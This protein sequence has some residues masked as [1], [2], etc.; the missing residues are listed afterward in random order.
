MPCSRGGTP[1]DA[2]KLHYKHDGSG[3]KGHRSAS[4]RLSRSPSFSPAPRRVGACQR[5]SPGLVCAAVAG[6]LGKGDGRG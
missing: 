4:L 5:V 6:A 3:G 2:A 1:G